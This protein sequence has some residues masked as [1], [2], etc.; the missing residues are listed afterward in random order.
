MTFSSTPSLA[1][2]LL[3]GFGLAAQ[4]SPLPPRLDLNQAAAEELAVLDQV[5]PE[6][7][8]AIVQLR[9][10][11]GGLPSVEAL[12]ILDLDEATLDA[13]RAG[14]EIA[15]P[16]VKVAGEKRYGT[17]DEVMLEFAREPQVSQV[18]QMAM[19]Y[20]NTHPEMVDR[21]LSAARTTYLLPQLSLKYQKDLNLNEDFSYEEVTDGDIEELLTGRD[22]DNDDTYEVK[23]R[24]DL[25]KLI[26]SS[27]RI[28]V[29]GEAQD[30]AKL[31]DKV[32]EEVTRL[33]FD[34]RRHQVDMLL[35]P[36]GGL[37]GQIE[38]ELKLQELTATLDAFTGGAFSAALPRG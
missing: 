16:V 5:E 29:I 22:Y 23:L 8:Q 24:W 37:S 2:L 3:S 19:A 13:L 31:R 14:T 1:L 6:E 4:A 26:M 36:P 21:W 12:R 18:Q 28:R 35:A 27:E 20:T 32:L 17:V 11:R 38:A 25:Q 33:Y 15:M 30:I 34:R 9:E 10:A 7:A